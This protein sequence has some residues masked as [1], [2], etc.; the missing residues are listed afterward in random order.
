[1][2]KQMDKLSKTNKERKQG[3]GDLNSENKLR[4]IPSNKSHRRTGE[5][6]WCAAV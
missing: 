4:C 1:M 5:Q 3:L 6:L 2:T